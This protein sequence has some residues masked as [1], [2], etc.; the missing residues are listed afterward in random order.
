MRGYTGCQSRLQDIF[1]ILVWFEHQELKDMVS[2]GFHVRLTSD[3]KIAFPRSKTPDHSVCISQECSTCQI[4]TSNRLQEPQSNDLS[5]NLIVGRVIDVLISLGQQYRMQQLTLTKII[6]L[7]S[8]H[9][10]LV[11]PAYE[12]STALIPAYKSPAANFPICSEFNYFLAKVPTH[13]WHVEGKMQEYMTWF[14]CRLVPAHVCTYVTIGNVFNI[15]TK[16]TDKA[17]GRFFL[18]VLNILCLRSFSS[19]LSSIGTQR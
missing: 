13:Y 12:I 7:S 10:L 2:W 4:K 17:S 1:L 14:G 11:D 9:Y 16:T 18:S 3:G 15:G 6:T 19:A 8:G 5:I